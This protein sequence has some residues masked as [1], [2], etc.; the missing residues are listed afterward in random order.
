MRILITVVFVAALVLAGGDVKAQNQNW[1]IYDSAHGVWVGTNNGKPVNTGAG[2]P[3]NVP[4]A[5]ATPQTAAT[6]ATPQ[7][8]A[9]A[10]EAQ[11]PAVA[12]ASQFGGATRVWTYTIG[13]NTGSPSTRPGGQANRSPSS[14]SRGQYSGRAPAGAAGY[15]HVYPVGHGS[16]YG[17]SPMFPR[18]RTMFSGGYHGAAYANGVYGSGTYG[19]G[20]YGTTSGGYPR[21]AGTFGRGAGF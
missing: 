18:S 4:Q 11:T 7:A 14:N 6:A 8:V 17:G 9:R 10:A 21:T 1:G 13:E 15:G 16:L 2:T 5:A 20:A 3:N 12:Q 19:D